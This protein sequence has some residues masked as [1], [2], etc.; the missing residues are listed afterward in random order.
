MKLKK[1]IPVLVLLVAAT[2]VLLWGWYYKGFPTDISSTVVSPF[3]ESV[4]MELDATDRQ[5]TIL[6][7]NVETMEPEYYI[8]HVTEIDG[9]EMFVEQKAEDGQWMTLARGKFPL[10]RTASPPLRIHFGENRIM[11]DWRNA[12]GALKSGE[13]RLVIRLYSENGAY[14]TVAI[15]F[16]IS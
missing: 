5:G 15:P 10:S 4:T 13:Y 6:V 16:S 2:G 14:D 12:Y 1:W 3:P 7:S 8:H 9:Y 11:V